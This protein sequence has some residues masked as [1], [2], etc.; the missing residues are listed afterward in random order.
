M[1]V[2]IIDINRFPGREEMENLIA[3]G[4]EYVVNCWGREGDFR[5]IDLARWERHDRPLI[6][7]E[8]MAGMFCRFFDWPPYSHTN[9]YQGPIVKPE[10]IEA[11]TYQHLAEGYNGI[12]YYVFADGQHPENGN[13]RMLPERD[14]NYQAPI[15]AAGTL[16]ESYRAIKRIGWFLRSF[17]SELLRAKP[18]P[19]WLTAFAHGSA[20]PGGEET[21]DLFEEYHAE[22]DEAEGTPRCRKVKAG[23]RV[24]R[25]LNLS[26]AN[27]A[28]LFNTNTRGAQWLRDIRLSV[29]PHGLCCEPAAEYPRRIQLALP[30]QRNKCL[31]FYVKLGEG[32]F[33]EYSTAELLDRRPFGRGVQV[34]LHADADET[35]ETRLVLPERVSYR[36]ARRIARPLGQPQHTLADRRAGGE[37]PNY[38]RQRPR[39]AARGPDG[40]RVGGA[41][42]GSR[43]TRWRRGRRH[44][45]HSPGELLS[46]RPD[47]GKRTV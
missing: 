12:N 31:P 47:Q 22:G 26:E 6:T 21:G 29:D 35:V 23:G 17:G 24:T 15:T 33:L 44:Q 45:P 42:L 19:S 13:E 16:R 46:K 27:F 28:F 1:D 8:S 38:D 36:S 3:A 37:F 10:Y 43:L 40:T 2:P 32:M 30:P 18:H 39:S 9:S 20:H 5:P 41:S 11:L 14:M 7:I 25:G 4:G 34:I